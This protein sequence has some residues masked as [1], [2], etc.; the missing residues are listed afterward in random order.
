MLWPVGIQVGKTARAREKNYVLVHV[1]SLAGATYGYL[2]YLPSETGKIQ[3]CR[4]SRDTK[5]D[6][7]CMYVPFMTER[8]MY[9]PSNHNQH[10]AKPY[11]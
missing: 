1:S 8:Y 2:R 5:R 7:L 3:V 4:N 11:R 9:A 6:I 10:Q